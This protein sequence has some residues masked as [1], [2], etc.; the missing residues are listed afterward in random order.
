MTNR[1]EELAD[2][3][4]ELRDKAAQDGYDGNLVADAGEDEWAEYYDDGYSVDEAL[5]IWRSLD[6]AADSWMV[7]IGAAIPRA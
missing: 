1:A 2:W 6:A 4:N 7:R 5:K 3:L